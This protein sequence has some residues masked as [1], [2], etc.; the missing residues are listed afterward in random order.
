MTGKLVSQTKKI[1]Q[2]SAFK[3][4]RNFVSPVHRIN[5]SYFAFIA[6]ISE[7]VKLEFKQFYLK[8]ILNLAGGGRLSR[9]FYCAIMMIC[10]NT[11][12]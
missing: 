2:I 3:M 7:N 10:G 9:L 8:L 12:V 5:E 4:F 11:V 1:D 6:T